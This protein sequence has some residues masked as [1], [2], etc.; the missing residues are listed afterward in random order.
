[1]SPLTPDEIRFFTREEYL[2][3]RGV[4]DAELMAR[5]PRAHVGHVGRCAGAHAA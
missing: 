1:M 5:A 4:L 2:I 3:K